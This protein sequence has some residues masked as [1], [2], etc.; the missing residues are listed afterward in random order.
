[1]VFYTGL[2]MFVPW[3]MKGGCVFMKRSVIS[4]VDFHHFF[5]V[6]QHDC[7]VGT[8][9]FGVSVILVYLIKNQYPNEEKQTLM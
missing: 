2:D 7:L 9:K 3:W 6:Q 4:F 5:L 1:M 8:Q